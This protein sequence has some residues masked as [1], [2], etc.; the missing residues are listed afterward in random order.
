MLVSLHVKNLALIDET[1]VEFGEGLNIL[2]GETGAGK[3][4]IIGSINLALGGRTDRELIRT[5]AEYAFVELVFYIESRMQ[6]EEIKELGIPIEEDGVLIIQRKIMVKKSICKICD[7]TVTAKV[8]KK[9]ASILIHIYG[10]HEH[11][12]LLD[13]R[14]YL[15]ILDYYAR[16]E[17]GTLLES[18]QKSYQSYHTLEQ[19]LMNMD[20]DKSSKNRELS[21]L[22]YEI[23]EIE[24]ANLEQGE[25]EQLENT[26]QKMVNAQKIIQSV[27]SAYHFAGSSQ[28]A[29]ELIGRAVRELNSVT[30]Y[31]E[32]VQELATQMEEVDN[33]L[34]DV[35]HQL[36][37]YQDTL[38]YKEEDFYSC[39]ERLNLINHLKAKYGKT[40]EEIMDY[41]QLQV[42]KR[43]KLLDHDEYLI[44]IQEEYS[45]SKK[46]LE[47]LCK[48][49]HLIR[50]EQK[51]NLENQL[52]EV[53]MDLN[54][55][56]IEFE[57]HVESKKQLSA[58][59][60]DEIEFF[61]S[62]NT[63]EKVR[64]LS[65]IASGGELSRIMLG[66]KTILA[67]K[68]QVD[69][70]I[71]DEI[72]TGISG[73]TAWKVA[74]KLS[75]LSKEN[76]VICITHLPQ[77]AAMADHHYQIKK[78]AHENQTMTTIVKMKEEEQIKELARLLSGD[79]ITDAVLENAKELKKLAKKT[80]HSKVN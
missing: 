45:K 75:V 31:D 2:S 20:I 36:S 39:E 40:I 65:Q 80:K 47:A 3:S 55:L 43:N 11:Q 16:E 59:G 57:I 49:A 38:E 52:K 34:S 37:L 58:K 21:L 71:F 12:T 9:L 35:N 76:Q 62:T 56:T 29:S 60:F 67:N 51:V 17:I 69:S 8:C 68:D 10:Q 4:V 78:K 61:I 19:Q 48:K 46:S 18:L 79:L 23:N 74:E 28:G 13:K 50:V 22:D 33:L 41:Q 73:K 44:K 1:E 7:E 5:G 32:K 6:L 27:S 42:E 77:I 24:E 70:L 54:F 14:N 72:D 15:S 26:Y 53:L 63:G 25:D 30:Q 66:L 64:P